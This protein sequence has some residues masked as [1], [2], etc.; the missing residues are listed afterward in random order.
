MHGTPYLQPFHVWRCCCLILLHSKLGAPDGFVHL[1][2][3]T[4]FRLLVHHLSSLPSDELLHS[5]IWLHH[6]LICISGHLLQFGIVFPCQ[7]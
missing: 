5:S 2:F 1:F 3:I 7:R 4:R 6:H